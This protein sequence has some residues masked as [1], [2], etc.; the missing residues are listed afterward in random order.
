[1]TSILTGAAPLSEEDGSAGASRIHT[2][3]EIGFMR[4]ALAAAQEAAGRG[5]VPVG[6]VVTRG[7][8]I[9]HSGATGHVTAPHL[10]FEVRRGGAAVDP[11]GL[12]GPRASL[13][14]KEGR[15]AS[16]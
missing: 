4:R 5:E 16:R 13:P 15:R 2:D 7:Q 6:A 10:H 11:L 3:Q 9:S 14:P 1:M 8:V 12:L